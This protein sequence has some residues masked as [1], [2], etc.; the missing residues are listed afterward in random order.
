MN[1]LLKFILLVLTVT[2]IGFV[3]VVGCDSSPELDD[4]EKN[5][6]DSTLSVGL[7][8]TDWSIYR[9]NPGLLGTSQAYLPNSLTLL[10]RFET[11]DEIK[12]SAV[13]DANRVYIG[14]SDEHVYCLDLTTGEEVW[15]FEA[16]DGIESPPTVKQ[17]TVFIGSLYG[18]LYAL[19][20]TN[21]QEKWRH[22]ADGQ[23]AGAANWITLPTGETAV[24]VGS[25]DSRVY[26]L[27]TQTGQP[28]WSFETESYVNGTPAVSN[29]WCTFGGCDAALYI[30]RL[31][32]G[33]EVGRIDTGSY[34]AASAAF[35]DD[36]IY[37]GNYD[38]LFIC[39]QVGEPNALWDYQI[40]GGA[41]FSSPAVGEEVVVFGDRDKQVHC[42]DKTNGEKRWI[43]KAL[44]NV[45]SSPVIC[46]DKVVFGSDDGRLYMISL[47][48]GK[49]VWSYELGQ[50]I[51]SS[52]AVA[53]GLVIVGCDDGFLYA[54]GSKP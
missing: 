48:E 29:Q 35:E 20:A 22:E 28:V 33:N 14:S 52:P 36:R 42:L 53:Q 23:I 1:T 45:D 51:T 46:G 26:C 7:P 9:G 13:I 2:G 47:A 49:K 25:H 12:S 31:A 8:E 38:G 15:S 11:Q 37:V 44:D 41:I 10:W 16:D 34:V 3:L 30:V 19:D 43:Y 40:P 17:D 24:L 21:G 54:F 32:D 6:P 4:T 39:A 18:S 5:A 27:D 50:P